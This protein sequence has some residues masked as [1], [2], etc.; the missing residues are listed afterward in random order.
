MIEVFERL[1]PQ[2]RQFKPVLPAARLG[3][4]NARIATGLGQ[5]GNHVVDEIDR[6]GPIVGVPTGTG[7]EQG[8]E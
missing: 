2:Q 5:H 4:A 3:V 8:A 1:E 6:G 7:K